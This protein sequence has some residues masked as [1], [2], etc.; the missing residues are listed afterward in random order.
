MTDGSYDP[1]KVQI[2]TPVNEFVVL[3][4]GTDAIGLSTKFCRFFLNL[5]E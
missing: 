3:V 2:I 5:V 4:A 1:T